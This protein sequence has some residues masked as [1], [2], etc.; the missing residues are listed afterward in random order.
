[1]E[2]GTAFNLRLGRFRGRPAARLCERSSRA[3]NQLPDVVTGSAGQRDHE[4]YPPGAPRSRDAWIR[5]AHGRPANAR[6]GPPFER[7]DVGAVDGSVVHVQC[8][9]SAWFSQQGM[10]QG[11]LPPT[12][13]HVRRAPVPWLFPPQYVERVFNSQPIALPGGFTDPGQPEPQPMQNGPPGSAH[14]D[15]A[16][17]GRSPNRRALNPVPP[18]D[19]CPSSKAL[20]RRTR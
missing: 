9:C 8:V 3:V 20:S 7:P 6:R 15:S 2:V 17:P 4:R 19:R 5:A 12:D 1:M 11:R 18:H 13:H 10:V 16:H 14:P